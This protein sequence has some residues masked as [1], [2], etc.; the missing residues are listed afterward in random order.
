LNEHRYFLFNGGMRP[1]ID[2][3]LRALMHLAP[4]TLEPAAMPHAL[5]L[6]DRRL[7]RARSSR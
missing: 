3:R 4:I 5:H 6:R 1:P 7:R 2:V